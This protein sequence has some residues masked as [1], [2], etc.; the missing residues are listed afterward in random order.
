[1]V[2]YRTLFFTLCDLKLR[3]AEIEPQKLLRGFKDSDVKVEQVANLLSTQSW[4]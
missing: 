2:A 1:M 3:A 4:V